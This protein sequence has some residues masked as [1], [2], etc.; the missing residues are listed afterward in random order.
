M[1]VFPV[2]LTLHMKKHSIDINSWYMISRVNSV[3]L[4][5]LVQVIKTVFIVCNYFFINSQVDL[6]SDIFCRDGTSWNHLLSLTRCVYSP[7]ELNSIL[8]AESSR[9]WCSLLRTSEGRL[10]Q[11]GRSAWRCLKYPRINLTSFPIAEHGAIAGRSAAEIDGNGRSGKKNPQRKQRMN[12][13][14]QT[15]DVVRETEEAAA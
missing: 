8:R 12:G 2:R 13:V 4:W 14:R 5:K 6:G 11:R 3:E 9:G 1:R 15:N 7:G 10:K